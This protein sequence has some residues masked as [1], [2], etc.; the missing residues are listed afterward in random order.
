MPGHRY[1]PGAHEAISSGEPTSRH[2]LLA[3]WQ[4]RSWRTDLAVLA[5]V[6]DGLRRLE[7][8]PDDEDDASLRPAGDPASAPAVLSAATGF[9]AAYPAERPVPDAEACLH[10]PSPAGSPATDEAVDVLPDAAIV[11]IRDT[12]RIVL[13][14]GDEPASYFYGRLFASHPRLRAMFPPA[15]DEQRDRL[16]RALA[17]I[18]DGLSSPEDLAEYLTQLGRD[19]R[20]YSVE[21]AM[22]DMVGEVLIATLRT[23]AGPAFTPG[24]EDAWRQ[25]YQAASALMIRAAQDDSA[26]APAYWTAEVVA[27]EQRGPGLAILTVAP[28]QPLPYLAGQHVTVQTPR[29][30]RVWRPYSVA[31]CPRED[32]LMTFHVRA[33]PGGWVSNALVHYADPGCELILGPALGT[34][35]LSLAGRRDLLFVAGG[36]GL[37]PVKAII[38]QAL[39]ES[40]GCPRQ[41]FL[42]YGAR[43]R[44]GLY[45]LPELYRLADAYPRF[46]LTPVTSDDPVF[47]GMQGNVGRVA[48]RYLP[49]RECEAYVAGPV[50]MVRE[51]IRALT[52]A[53]IPRERIHYDDALLAE[54]RHANAQGSS[55]ET[56]KPSQT[57]PRDT[58]AETA[59][60]DCDSD[61]DEAGSGAEGEPAKLEQV[62]GGVLA[63][64]HHTRQD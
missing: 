10:V 50:A 26:L 49:H 21:P 39:R 17:R 19:H 16:L 42:F 60:Q 44:D 62:P 43:T 55:G 33:V 51:T 6:R 38:E 28:D 7:A 9:D 11:S 64:R 34:M 5:R 31:N 4:R 22:Y 63:G 48:A 58:A 1:L 15:M 8:E 53:G 18:V 61:D 29:W 2:G 45:D 47:D 23:F 14:A 25:A 41:I 12:F 52:R 20:K 35:S 46:F 13:A 56:A 59:Q 37:S 36:T 24:A 30:P 3:W 54:D 57:S 27:N 32:G 40:S